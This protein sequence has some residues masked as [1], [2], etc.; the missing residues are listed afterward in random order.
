MP[1]QATITSVIGPGKTVTTLVLTGLRVFNLELAGKSVLHTESDLGSRDFDIAAT[2]TLTVSIA[3]GV[4]E[5]VVS[6]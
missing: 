4:A 6:Q 3:A 1:S 2:D 5:I